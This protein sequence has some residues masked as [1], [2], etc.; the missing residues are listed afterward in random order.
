MDVIIDFSK[1]KIGDK[2]FLENRLV[3]ED[4]ADRTGELRNPGTQI[5]RF[6]VDRDAPDHSQ[7]PSTLRPLLDID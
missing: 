6:D 2:L 7:V 4:G 5:L 3:Q 1:Y